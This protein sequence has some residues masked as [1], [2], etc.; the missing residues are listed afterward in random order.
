MGA[1]GGVRFEGMMGKRDGGG[2]DINPFA[3]A[4]RQSIL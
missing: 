1:G 2:E 3:K 4:F